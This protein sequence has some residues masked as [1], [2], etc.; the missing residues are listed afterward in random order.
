MAE[1]APIADNSR[2]TGVDIRAHLYAKTTT[3]T[4]LTT[5]AHDNFTFYLMNGASPQTITIPS[6]SVTPYDVGAVITFIQIGTSPF[7]VAPA[8]GVTINTALSSLISKGQ[9]NVSQVMNIGKDSWV[10][11]G[12]LGG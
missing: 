5:V 4:S 9:Y 12:G 6:S 10:A 8:S 3:V 7:T 11:F 1:L 2:Y